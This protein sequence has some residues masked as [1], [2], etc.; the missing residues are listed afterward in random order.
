[1]TVV[2]EILTA[3]L[4]VAGTFFS[5]VAVS[6]Y[7]RLP[8]VYSRLHAAGMAATFSIVLLLLS[9][10]LLLG[11]SVVKVVVLVVFLLIIAPVG[12]HAISSAAYRMGVALKGKGG[13]P[14]PDALSETESR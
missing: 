6:G 2:L 11:V 3:V 7:V 4:V 9:T 12:S 5:Y 14:A 10:P 1:M 8:D 13:N